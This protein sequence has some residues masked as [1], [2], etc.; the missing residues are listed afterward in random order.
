MS[1][2]PGERESLKTL[3][4][5]IPPH[6]QVPSPPI[7]QKVAIRA[8][9]SAITPS[10]PLWARIALVLVPLVLALGIGFVVVE[11]SGDYAHNDALKW[12]VVAAILTGGAVAIG[13]IGLPFAI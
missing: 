8:K 2:E 5:A 12:T 9:R 6:P 10:I 7:D 13:L 11:V 1:T 3:V 4:G